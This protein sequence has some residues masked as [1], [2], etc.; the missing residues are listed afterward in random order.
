M[1]TEKA[2]GRIEVTTYL[3]L[4]F[5]WS[6]GMVVI[7]TLAKSWQKRKKRTALLDGRHLGFSPEL[8]SIESME[9]DYL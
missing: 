1:S 7:K 8:N 5:D 9:I 2:R 3:V 6:V 4:G